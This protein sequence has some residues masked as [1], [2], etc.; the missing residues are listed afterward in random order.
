M[1]KS[2][3]LINTLYFLCRDSYQEVWMTL[4]GRRRR[5]RENDYLE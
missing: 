5:T 1:P 3:L 4:V 2:A